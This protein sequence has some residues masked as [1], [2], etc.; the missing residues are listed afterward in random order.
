MDSSN[1]KLNLGCGGVTPDGYI[2][3]DCSPNA[4]LSK[5]PFYN[6]IKFI[7]YKLRLISDGAYKANWSSNVRYC[8]LDK[9]FPKLPTSSCSVIYTSH[10]LEHIEKE[11][12]IRLLANCYEALSNNG[13]LRIAVPDLYSEAKSYIWEYEE[14]L[15]YNK[16]DFKSGENFIRLMVSRKPRHAHK[17]MYD[18]L[19]LRDILGE[20]GYVNIQQMDFCEST[21]SDIALLEH[22]KDSLFVECKK[23][24]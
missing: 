16:T 8:N 22:R 23:S 17:W 21:I 20:L 11:S 3:I 2:N 18:F 9:T 13:I 12:A 1:L 5:F 15:K 24:R 14:S 7:L 6:F 4:L 19:L 10:F